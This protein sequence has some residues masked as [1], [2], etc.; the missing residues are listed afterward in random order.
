M[1]RLKTKSSRLQNKAQ[2]LISVFTKVTDGLIK[3]NADLGK[4]SDE[5]VAKSKHYLDVS[6][7][8][9]TQIQA[10]LR[11]IQRIQQILE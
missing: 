5:A 2:G 11:I 3:V 10:N 1:S 9:T 6:T 4:I 7:E 8:A